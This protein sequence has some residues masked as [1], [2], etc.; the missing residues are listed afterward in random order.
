[1]IK[2]YF[3]NSI[4]HDEDEAR[5]WFEARIWPDGCI[6]PGCGGTQDRIRKLEGKAHRAGLYQC[7]RCRRQF[8]ATVGTFMER[9]RIQSTK[10]LLA[11]FLTS[12]CKES[13]S[14][15]QISHLLGVSYKSTWFMI[16]RIRKTMR[17]SSLGIEPPGKQ[18]VLQNA[19]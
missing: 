15:H 14:V 3:Q 12:A 16:H 10:W 18:S 6:C 1:M 17:E 19:E 7:N 5:A 8:T 13:L 11:I 9:S 2:S 4:F